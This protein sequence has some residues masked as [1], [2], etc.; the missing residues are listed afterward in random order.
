MSTQKLTILYRTE[1][2]ADELLER[3]TVDF[4]LPFMDDPNNTHLFNDIYG[5]LRTLTRHAN[6]NGKIHRSTQTVTKNLFLGFGDEIF[7]KLLKHKD[8]LLNRGYESGSAKLREACDSFWMTFSCGKSM[9]HVKCQ[10]VIKSNKCT[11]FSHGTS[12]RCIDHI[13]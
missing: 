13:D 8:A 2:G 4:L 6:N 1:N 9:T 5:T 11:S 12:A 7:A 3:G 10:S